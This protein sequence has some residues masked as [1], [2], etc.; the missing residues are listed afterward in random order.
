MHKGP[1][2]MDTAVFQ[3]S[4]PARLPDQK[5]LDYWIVGAWKI[6]GKWNGLATWSEKHLNFCMELC[7][8]SILGGYSGYSQH[9]SSNLAS[10]EC[11]S[12]A[13]Y[14]EIAWKRW[15]LTGLSAS[16]AWQMASWF[17]GSGPC[18]IFDLQEMEAA[19]YPKNDWS[20]WISNPFPQIWN[21]PPRN[22][23]RG[24][25]L[26]ILGVDMGVVYLML[27]DEIIIMQPVIWERFVK[28]QKIPCLTVWPMFCWWR[29]WR[30]CL[31]SMIDAHHS[32]LQGVIPQQL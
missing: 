8:A 7:Q 9:C 20:W 1:K 21:T 29:Q 10:L 11:I 12:R 25:D 5:P 2:V 23:G 30:V 3:F 4:F 24:W 6:A 28:R 14:P 17:L 15:R 26:F 31:M 13:W 19:S 27:G 18:E 32:G 16:R 22:Y